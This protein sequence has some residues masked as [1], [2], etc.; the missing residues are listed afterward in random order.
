MTQG[1]DPW[2]PCGGIILADTEDW[3][4]PRCY[5]CYLAMGEPQKEP[6]HAAEKENPPDDT[7]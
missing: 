7:I 1:K 5:E 2:C 4:I 3:N 6:I